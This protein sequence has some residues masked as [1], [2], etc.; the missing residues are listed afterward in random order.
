MGEGGGVVGWVEGECVLVL[1]LGSAY[2][3][4]GLSAAWCLRLPFMVLKL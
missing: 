4:K 1:V 2:Q 3:Q